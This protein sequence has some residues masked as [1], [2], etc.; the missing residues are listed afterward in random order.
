VIYLAPHAIEATGENAIP[1]TLAAF[2]AERHGS[3]RD[4]SVV[5]ANQVFHTGADAM[6]R[7][8]ARSFF[9]GEVVLGGKYVMVDDVTTLGGTL[10]DLADYIQGNGGEVLGS[11]LLVNAARSGR[12]IPSQAVIRQIER[13]YGDEVRETF[14]IEP[15]ALT[16]E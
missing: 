8:I 15:A 13:R 3:Q 6:Q 9:F 2:L 10:A 16:A 12:L 4:A 5:Q 7:L 11:V 1:E 14:G